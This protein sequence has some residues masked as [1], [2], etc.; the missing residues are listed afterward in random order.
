MIALVIGAGEEHTVTFVGLD[1]GEQVFK[2]LFVA[3]LEVVL[4]ANGFGESKVFGASV[5]GK[6]AKPNTGKRA[7]P[8]GISRGPLSGGALIF[9]SSTSFASPPCTGLVMIEGF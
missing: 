2:L 9:S 3:G 7:T 4:G 8:C 5:W 6:M 1:E